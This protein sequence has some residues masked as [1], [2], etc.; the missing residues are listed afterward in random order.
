GGASASGRR[1]ARRSGWLTASTTASPTA[2][3]AWPHAC[4]PSACSGS[5]AD[6]TGPA[7]ARPSPASWRK[8]PQAAARAA[9]HERRR[10]APKALSAAVRSTEAC[11]VSAA[12]W[13]PAPLLQASVLLHGAALGAGLW[14]PGWWP[15]LASGVLANHLAV[16]GAGLWPRSQLLGPNWVR[17]PE[18]AA[19]RGGFAITI[20]DGPDPEVTPRVLDLL[21]E[22]GARASFF[23]IGRRAEAAPALCREIVS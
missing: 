22:L 6:T 17:L 12:R 5:M 13:R 18:A 23:C 7:G 16:A 21:D 11:P 8:G 15:W 20:D 9:G 1:P 14:Q 19:A 4:P 3:T 10:A 2:W